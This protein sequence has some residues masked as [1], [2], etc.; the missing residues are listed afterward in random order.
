MITLLGS[1]I[2]FG[3]SFVPEVLNYFKAGQ[4]QKHKLQ[5]MK[6]EFELMEKRN[7]MTLRLTD[8]QAGIEE[9]KGLY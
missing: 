7:E 1:L 3:T 5:Q 6:L 9:T 2:G 4:D 8:M